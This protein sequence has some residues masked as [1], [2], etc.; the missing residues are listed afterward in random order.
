MFWQASGC[1]VVLCHTQYGYGHVQRRQKTTTVAK[2]L[3]GCVFTAGSEVPPGRFH[4]GG[5]KVAHGRAGT[6]GV[7][8]CPRGMSSL[9]GSK[10]LPGMSSP[11]SVQTCPRPCLHRGGLKVLAGRVPPRGFKSAPGRYRWGS[12]VPPLGPKSA[13]RVCPPTG[14]QKCPIGRGSKSAP[15]NGEECPLTTSALGTRI[16]L[17]KKILPAMQLAL[18]TLVA[19]PAHCPRS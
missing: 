16:F 5:S 18:L 17:L 7:Q 8:K 1:V 15:A 12:K 11:G 10:V 13:P 2:V 14:A 4:R 3:P 9:W 19:R 6:S